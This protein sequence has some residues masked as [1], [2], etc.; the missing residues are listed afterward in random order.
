[1]V[2]WKSTTKRIA[3]L[4]LS[5]FLMTGITITAFAQADENEDTWVESKSENNN[6]TDIDSESSSKSSDSEDTVKSAEDNTAASL[7]ESNAEKDT[8]SG[9]QD[10][11]ADRSGDGEQNSERADGEKIDRSSSFTTLGSAQVK[12]DI[13][14]GSSKEFLT[15]VTKNNQTF[16][17]VI[18]RSTTT[19]NVYL[20]SNVDENDL[21][22]FLDGAADGNTE[23][24]QT[25]AIL[26]PEITREEEATTA[27]D[28]KEDKDKEER[29]VLPFGNGFMIFILLTVVAGLV[30][31]YYFK[32]YKP[33]HEEEDDQEN[34]GL[35][36]SQ[37]YDEEE[38]DEG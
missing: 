7:D 31:G 29:K 21:Q 26:L 13:R 17:L 19:D 37:S 23:E 4:I 8:E 12:D 15:I 18:D 22:E 38:V 3:I 9:K 36:D 14:D 33:G 10:N 2:K 11:S 6:E 35:E 5:L 34:E 24:G 16:Y 25:P 28:Q 20:L 1:M 32:I 27:A 30:S